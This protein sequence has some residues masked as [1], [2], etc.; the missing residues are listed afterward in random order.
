MRF[1]LVVGLIVSLFLFSIFWV[2]EGRSGGFSPMDGP[3]LVVE[4]YEINFGDKE[5]GAPLGGPQMIYV[6]NTGLADSKLFLEGGYNIFP[7]PGTDLKDFVVMYEDCLGPGKYVLGGKKCDIRVYFTPQSEKE[8]MQ[9][10][11]VYVGDSVNPYVVTLKG[12]GVSKMP[13]VVPPPPPKEVMEKSMLEPPAPTL[14]MMSPGAE[15]HTG[16]SGEG[17]NSEGSGGGSVSSGCS[18]QSSIGFNFTSIA[19]PVALIV[20][21]GWRQVHRSFRKLN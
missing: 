9:D 6:K 11:Y 21:L 5:V 18:L 3:Y 13:G 16:G 4:P 10:I 12:K 15:P 19:F 8:K 1:H 7:K 14:P 17:G 20:C 2:G